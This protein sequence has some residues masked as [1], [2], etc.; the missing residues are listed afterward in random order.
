MSQASDVAHKTA[1]ATWHVPY[2]GNHFS[3]DLLSW[4]AMTEF[5]GAAH[6]L[7]GAQE[8]NGDIALLSE[9]MIHIKISLTKAMFW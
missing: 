4:S 7:K 2:L 5:Q 8:R 1:E 6:A 9:H 3:W